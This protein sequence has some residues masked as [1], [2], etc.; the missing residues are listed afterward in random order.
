MGEQKPVESVLAAH[1]HGHRP[2]ASLALLMLALAPLSPAPRHFRQTRPE[3]PSRHDNLA[4][5]GPVRVSFG[6]DWY[7]GHPRDSRMRH[8][9]AAGPKPRPLATIRAALAGEAVVDVR[10]FRRAAS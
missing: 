3:A 4:S 8:G 10:G 5:G 2:A 1:A 6:G 9:H 7:L